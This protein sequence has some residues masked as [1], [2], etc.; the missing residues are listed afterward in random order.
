MYHTIGNAILYVYNYGQS[1]LYVL[2]A[3]LLAAVNQK[4]FFR[5]EGTAVM[6]V[7]SKAELFCMALLFG[8]AVGAAL[9]P[10]DVTLMYSGRAALLYM[11]KGILLSGI[12]TAAILAFTDFVA[13]RFKAVGAVFF[14]SV[15]LFCIFELLLLDNPAIE[16]WAATYYALDYSMGFGS[17]L[18]IGSVLHLFYDD[19]LSNTV[20]VRFVL[21]FMAIF[22]FLLAFLFTEWYCRAK[23]ENKKGI[24][25]IML[26]FLASPASFGAMA[27]NFGRL[28]VYGYFALALIILWGSL[29]AKKTALK[30]TGYILICAVMMLI[31]QGNIFLAFPGIFAIM[32]SECAKDGKWSG[33]ELCGTVITT[34]FTG[35]MFFFTQFYNPAFSDTNENALKEY[36]ASKTD[37]EFASGP[38]IYEYF[39]PLKKTWETINYPYFSHEISDSAFLPW[40]GTAFTALLMMPVIVLIAIFWKRAYAHFKNAGMGA[41]KNPVTWMLLS[42]L[43]IIP[44]FLLNI[45]W[46]RWFIALFFVQISVICVMMRRSFAGADETLSLLSGLVLKYKWPAVLLVVYL[47]SLGNFYDCG[48]IDTVYKMLS[49]LLGTQFPVIS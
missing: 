1:L 14:L 12:L 37:M 6:Q 15:F 30:Y 39:R 5:A 44:D 43:V 20:A 36:I 25:F 33:K 23:E 3:L 7:I 41:L 32:I 26:A 8:G 45:D 31:Y 17:R 42:F 4:K 47:Y 24:L 13:A 49:T 27:E 38:L 29:M 10:G 34:A 9:V 48:F 19:F 35:F 18:F 22:A 11:L 28:E 40:I 46:G 2:V 21:V 16:D